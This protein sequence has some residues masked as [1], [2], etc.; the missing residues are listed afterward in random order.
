[1]Q[2]IC[3]SIRIS[4]GLAVKVHRFANAGRK[5]SICS[6][7]TEI[8]SLEETEQTSGPPAPISSGRAGCGV[9]AVVILLVF[10]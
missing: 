5:H 6:I 9:V 4:A 1:M 8:S 3:C 2:V 7:T 10:F